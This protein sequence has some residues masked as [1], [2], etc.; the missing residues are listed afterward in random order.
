MVGVIRFRRLQWLTFEAIHANSVVVLLGKE[1]TFITPRTLVNT[2]LE[3]PVPK[4]TDG[5]KTFSRC[6]LANVG[7][8]KDLKVDSDGLQSAVSNFSLAIFTTTGIIGK[9]HCTSQVSLP[10][11]HNTSSTLEF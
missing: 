6:T 4:L 2:L 3:A 11:G 9:M 7:L 1:T 10:S 5:A 8:L